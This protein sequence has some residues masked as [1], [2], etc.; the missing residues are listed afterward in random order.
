MH[1]ASALLDLDNPAFRWFAVTAAIAL[2]KLMLAPWL[3]VA[4]ML[5]ANAGFRSPEDARASPVNPNPSPTQ[6]DPNEYVERA[7]RI[8]L[9][10]L[11]SI[12]GFVLAG[13]LFVLCEPPLWL[14]Q[15][16]F[17]AYLAGRGAHFIAYLR[18]DMHELRAVPWTVSSV[19]VLV[20]VGWV[21][22]RAALGV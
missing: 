15:A 7:R 13:A 16:V 19:A 17:L 21:G 10:D 20:M 4:R 9:N 5:R 22:W 12:P 1:D 2:A 18:G 6:L 8:H 3:T 11:E 14:A